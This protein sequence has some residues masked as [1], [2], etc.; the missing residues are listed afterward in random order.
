MDLA[1]RAVSWLFRYHL[2][3]LRGRNFN[4]IDASDHHEA[5]ILT[6]DAATRL[7]PG[8]NPIGKRFRLFDNQN[9]PTGWIRVVSISADVVQ[10][11]Q[12]S[13]P[14]PLLLVPYRQEDWAT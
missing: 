4:E 8:Q 13:H 9:K 12:E 11:L 1:R 10:E 2:P 7:W 5:A 6:R 14:K 3:L